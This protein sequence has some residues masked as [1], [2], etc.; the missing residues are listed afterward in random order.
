MIKEFEAQREKRRIIEWIREWFHSHGETKNA[1]VGISG[2]KDS[3]IVA[4][5]LAEALGK[6][7]VYG[8]MMPNGVQKDIN[9]SNKV[10]NLLGIHSAT[11]NIKES[12][13]SIL[14]QINPE[15]GKYTDMTYINLAPRLRMTALYAFAQS[16]NGFVANTSNLSED[17]VGY[18]TKWGDSS[19]DFA[20]IADYLA[21][22][23]I[24]IGK[25]LDLP[26]ELIY[27]TPSDGL[28][29]KTDE[30]NL[31][32]NYEVLDDYIISGIC[33]NDEIKDKIENLHIMNQHKFKPIPKCEYNKRRF[34]I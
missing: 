21:T 4:A 7:R 15:A 20:P 26:D 25:E 32:F 19:G 31:G 27:K 11:I 13:D 24:A 17:Y 9:D 16:F 28:C 34:Y 12:F 1:I 14:A 3:T 23:V 8:V 6:D 30:D 5:L 33:I 10:I 29:G 18:C 2:G 22:E